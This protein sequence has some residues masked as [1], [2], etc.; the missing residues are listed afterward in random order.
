MS[1]L[2]IQVPFPV[3]QDRDGQPLDNGYVWLGVANL[4]PQINPVVAYFDSAL[5]IIAA[6]PLRTINGYISNAGTPAQVYVDGV[7]F[8]IL[9]QDSKG[10]MVYNFPDGTG[11]DPSLDSCSVTYDPPFAGSVPYPVCKKL[12][13][14]VSVMDFGAVGDGVEDDTVAI[15]AAINNGPTYFPTGT[16]R[17]TSSIILPS[18]AKVFGAG[19]NKTLVKSEVIGDSLFKCTVEAIFINI[20]DM[21]LEGNNLTGVSG[22]G[23]AINFI[24]PTSGGAFSPQQSVLERL[25][26]SK[27]RGQDIRTSGVATTICSAGVIMYDALQNICRDVYVADCGHGFYMATTQNCR[28]ENC[29]AVDIDKFALIAYDNENL[30]VD[31]CDLLNA[32]DGVV[33][34]GYPSTSFSWGS[35]VALSYGNSGFALR[36]SKLKNIDA[37][38]ALIRSIVSINDVYDKNWLRSTTYTDVLHQAIYGFRTYNI[39]ITNNEFSPANDGFSAT[40]KFKQITLEN[41]SAT[42]PMICRIVG[43]TFGD[44]SGMDIAWNIKLIG[45]ASSRAFTTIIENNQ[46]GYNAARSSACVINADIAFD[47]CTLQNSRVGTNLHLAATNVTRD[48]GILGSTVVDN[49]NKIGP[50][51]FATNGGTITA[52]YSGIDQSVLWGS[53]AYNPPSLINGARDTTTVTVAGATLTYPDIQLL[54]TVGFSKDLQGVQI[55]SY[56]SSANTVTVIFQNN[57][58]GTVNVDS[59]AIYVKVEKYGP[60]SL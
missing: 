13:Q 59:G 9:V 25:E 22:N 5:T 57:T 58:G 54:T 21:S 27:F 6:Q 34:P 50:A 48:V 41:T 15:Q 29:A 28:L 60:P 43:N 56:I 19:V 33:D 11:I 51:S 36:N 26:I 4:N 40:Q 2:S 10:S 32:G 3:F 20:S 53:A 14:I 37:G 49:Q 12:E 44:V 35:G 46:F 17:V 18:N 8:S 23:H 38:D 45:S 24:D 39:Q 42:E 47:T 31:K 30:I 55:F 16:Y 1:A 52:E 7:N